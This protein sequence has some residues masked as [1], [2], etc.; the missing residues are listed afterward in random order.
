MAPPDSRTSV[1]DPAS[2]L[3]RGASGHAYHEG[4]RALAP[5]AE[6]WVLNLRASKF[7]RWV[8][9]SD[10]VFELGVGSGWNLAHLNCARKLGCDAAEFLADRLRQLGIEFCRHTAD[11]PTA[12]ADVVLCHQT[13]EH[14]LEPAAALRELARIAKPGG[15]I[16]VHVPWEV[17]RR[18]AR[19]DPS[20][21]NHHLY[22]WN[23]QNLGNLATV[24]GWTIERLCVRRYG[25]DRFAANLAARCRLGEGGFRALRAVLVAVR[26]LREV[27]LIARR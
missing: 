19:F 6:A 18:Y 11:V 24:L 9:P 7:Q 21:P 4:K 2:D 8:R 20:E 1:D 13:L 10:V 12:H 5:Q 23:A 22:H 14:L 17:E 26:P 16:L 27:E 25:Y 3:Y 15:R